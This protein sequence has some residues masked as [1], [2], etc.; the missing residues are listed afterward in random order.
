LRP[1][2]SGR[3][4]IEVRLAAALLVLLSFALASC[5]RPGPPQIAPEDSGPDDT[6]PAP[7]QDSDGDGLC[8]AFEAE[9]RTDP[10]SADTDLDGFS[11]Y[12]ESQTGSDP[13]MIDSPNRDL[14]VFLREAPGSYVDVPISFSVR[15]VGETF[16]GSYL[17]QP[18]L[19]PDDGTTALTFYAGGMT[20]GASPME[21]VRGTIDNERFRGVFGRTLLAFSLRFEQRQDPRGCMRAFPFA[22]S[23]KRD[24]G[25]YAGTV[26]HWLVIAPAGMQPGA[27]GS[28]WCGPSDGTCH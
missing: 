20:V 27:P 7:G 13:F 9:R 6:G 16:L 25:S 15:G 2:V 10:L 23:L 5:R 17:P 18:M 24:D 12:V 1:D 3:T 11:D 21:N 28:V 26:P 4:L 22:Y 19:I 14:L 8:D